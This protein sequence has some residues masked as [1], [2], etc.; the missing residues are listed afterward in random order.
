MSHVTINQLQALAAT[1]VIMLAATACGSSSSTP[2]AAAGLLTEAR[3]ALD[4]GDYRRASLLLDS[5]DSAYPEAIGTRSEAMKL[6]PRAIEGLTVDAIAEADSAIARAERE[7]ASLQPDMVLHENREIGESYYVPRGIDRGASFINSTGITVRVNSGTGTLYLVSS[8]NPG[9]IA[10]RYVVLGDDG[11]VSVSTDT[12]AAGS[13]A[14]FV[15]GNSELLEFL[16]RYCTRLADFFIS[17]DGQP[18]TA[19]INGDNGSRSVKIDRRAAAAMAQAARLSKA[20]TIA[21]ENA[22]E[23]ER[24]TRALQVAKSQQSSAR[25]NG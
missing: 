9:R 25:S 10:Q 1:A 8:V 21:R 19:T 17:H 23:R 22:L 15:S 3:E 12:I 16:P 7:I 18:F 14:N 5:I 20:V 6:R 13:Q 2:D 4:S 24:L 11:G